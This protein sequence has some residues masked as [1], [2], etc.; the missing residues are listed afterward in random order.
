MHER[1]RTR[2]NLQADTD[3][4]RGDLWDDILWW[5]E[6]LLRHRRR[7]GLQDHHERSIHHRAFI[8]RDKRREPAV[9]ADTGFGRC[10]VWKHDRQWRAVRRWL[11]YDLP[12]DHERRADDAPHVRLPD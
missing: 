7:D 11:R 3:T 5:R 2:P 10:L 12:T 8:Q 4:E 6:W 9:R 1:R